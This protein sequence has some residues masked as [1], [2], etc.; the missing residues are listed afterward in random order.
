MKC[1]ACEYGFNEAVKNGIEFESLCK[2]H[3]KLAKQFL[4]TVA[5]LAS[6]VSKKKIHV[7]E[8]K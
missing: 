4:N 3:R 8:N 7:I 6:A 5:D 1:Y 2:K